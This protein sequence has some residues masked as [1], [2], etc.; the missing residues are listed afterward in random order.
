MNKNDLE[1]HAFFTTNGK[2]VW[3]LRS[4]RL[5]PTCRLE[6]LEDPDKSESFGMGGLTAQTFHRI[7]MPEISN[8]QT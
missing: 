5:E 8:E 2:D 1:Q 4:F 3:K 7:K 6:N